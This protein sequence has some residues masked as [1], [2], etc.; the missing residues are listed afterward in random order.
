MRA[1]TPGRRLASKESGQTLTNLRIPRR[2]RPNDPVLRPGAAYVSG[3]LCEFSF[4]VH[5][6]GGTPQI[7]LIGCPGVGVSS[8]YEFGCTHRAALVAGSRDASARRRHADLRSG[9][10]RCNAD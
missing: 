6:E 7:P 1:L 9:V 8:R 4:G 10:R 3:P 2:T 5:A